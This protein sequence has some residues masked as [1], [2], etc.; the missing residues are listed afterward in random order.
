MPK[1][2]FANLPE[3]KRKPIMQA[4]LEEFSRCS[5]HRASVNAICRNAGIP[6]G[7]FYQYFDNKQ[8]LYVHL[9][10]TVLEQKQTM[11]RESLEQSEALGFS[12]RLKALYAAGFSFAAAHPLL[13]ELGGRFAAETDPAVTGPVLA[14][15]KRPTEDVF[16]S[17]VVNAQKAGDIRSDL[18]VEQVMLLLFAVNH[19]IGEAVRGFRDAQHEN[20]AENDGNGP[21]KVAV[22]ANRLLD[23]VLPMVLHGIGA[24]GPGHADS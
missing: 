2:T 15:A 12:D 5:Y 10:T 3:G 14:A 19:Q 23:G 21:G 13:A 11:L 7:S 20:A 17:L 6:K 9:M 24:R 4:A 18:P 1:D 8:E 16:A 22:E